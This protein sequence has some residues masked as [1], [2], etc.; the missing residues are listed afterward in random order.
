MG[1]AAGVIPPG[2]CQREIPRRLCFGTT[3]LL[4]TGRSAASPTRVTGVLGCVA[5]ERPLGLNAPVV[6]T[7]PKYAG[8]EFIDGRREEWFALPRRTDVHD[9]SMTRCFG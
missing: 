7:H 6:V 5:E 4:G 1:D 3:D 9:G 2:R 8:L